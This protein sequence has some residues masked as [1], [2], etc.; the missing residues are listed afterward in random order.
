MAANPGVRDEA[1]STLSSSF[2]SPDQNP[3]LPAL[4]QP[5][6]MHEQHPYMGAA[7]ISVM[8]M[9]SVHQAGNVTYGSLPQMQVAPSAFLAPMPAAPATS[10]PSVIQQAQLVIPGMTRFPS[11][12]LQP[13]GTG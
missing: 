1:I 2:A 3:Q 13:K 10:L 7:E 8:P 11:M 4:A 6:G 5:P 12:P 9:P